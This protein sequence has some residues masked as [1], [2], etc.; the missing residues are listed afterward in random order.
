MSR[1]VLDRSSIKH[2]DLVAFDYQGRHGVAIMENG[3]EFRAAYNIFHEEGRVWAYDYLPPESEI[4]LYAPDKD[5]MMLAIAHLYSAEDEYEMDNLLSL[6]Q[7]GIKGH[8]IAVR[9]AFNQLQQAIAD[10]NDI[11]K[12]VIEKLHAQR[13]SEQKRREQERERATDAAHRMEKLHAKQARLVEEQEQTIKDLK[14]EIAELKKVPTEDA[15]V[16]RF[17]SETKK[18]FKHHRENA[19]DIRKVFLKMGRTD[20]EAEL[21]A[22]IE[23][24]EVKPIVQKNVNSQ[25]FNGTINESEFNRNGETDHEA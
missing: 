22:F 21:D 3:N 12:L 7:K 16:K 8:N 2:G 24:G 17:V 19:D 10:E 5:D 20:A 14:A 15:F 23:M 18:M 25:V 11:H 9:E 1:P 13:K 4:T 6:W